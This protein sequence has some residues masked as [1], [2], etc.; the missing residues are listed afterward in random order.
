MVETLA[1]GAFTADSTEDEQIELIEEDLFE[2]IDEKI[3]ALHS[4]VKDLVIQWTDK[5]ESL[6]LKHI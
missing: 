5:I 2:D 6:A 1:N 4:E 3:C